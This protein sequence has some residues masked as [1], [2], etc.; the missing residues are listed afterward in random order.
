VVRVSLTRLLHTNKSRCTEIS[1][2]F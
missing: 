2:S 1:E